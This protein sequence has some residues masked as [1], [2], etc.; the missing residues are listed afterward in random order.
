[1]EEDK[2]NV[3]IQVSVTEKE[4]QP[5]V[6]VCISKLATD[7]ELRRA[8]SALVIAVSYSDK[9][10]DLYI[11]ACEDAAEILR[12]NPHIDVVEVNEEMRA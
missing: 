11:E 1:M 3:I 8:F 9:F 4:D 6:E 2:D 10:R 7:K 5:A 12:K